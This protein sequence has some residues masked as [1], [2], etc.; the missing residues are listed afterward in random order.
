MKE[1]QAKE[2]LTSLL[3]E[4]QETRTKLA[5]LQQRMSGLK[6]VIEGYVELFPDLSVQV[7]DLVGFPRPEDEAERAAMLRRS[8]LRREQMMDLEREPASGQRRLEVYPPPEGGLASAPTVTASRQG[9]PDS[10]DRPRGQEAV[11]RVMQESVGKWW[12][13]GLVTEELSKRG[14]LP[15]SDNPANAV[16]AALDRL[17][18]IED[19]GFRKDRGKSGAVTYSYRPFELRAAPGPA[20]GAT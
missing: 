17:V 9:V 1:A 7:Q 5:T 19:S 10:D 13:V 3:T 2:I 6:K 14:W 20:E 8:R 11:V 16:R 15:E 12:P 18:A 4:Y